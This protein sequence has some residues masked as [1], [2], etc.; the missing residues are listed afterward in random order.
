MNNIASMA[1]I[2]IQNFSSP[3]ADGAQLSC[4]RKPL[5]IPSS[6]PPSDFWNYSLRQTGRLEVWTTLLVSP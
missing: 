3:I 5:N 2:L 1:L 6:S 4:G